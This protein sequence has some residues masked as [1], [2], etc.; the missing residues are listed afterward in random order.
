MLDKAAALYAEERYADAACVYQQIIA[1]EGVAAEVYYNLGNCYYKL[2]NIA[3]SI[4]SYERALR[5]DP[6]DSDTKTNLALARG[7]TQDKVAPA[8]EMFFVSWWKQ[9]TNAMSLAA[10]MTISAIAFILLLA[11]IL[12][13]AFMSDIRLR[14]AGVCVSLVCL[15]VTIAVL[16]HSA[17]SCR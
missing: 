8:S 5:L 17:Q 16:T 15:V 3:L 11:G 9:L 12:V 1:E 6:S 13:Y 4:L 14:K 7:K 2:D 10:W